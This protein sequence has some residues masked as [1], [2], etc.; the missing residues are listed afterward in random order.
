[1]DWHR[2]VFAWAGL[3]MASRI[4][5]ELAVATDLLD[6]V[7]GPISQRARWIITGASLAVWGNFLPK[8]LSPWR[9]EDEPFDW[10]RVHRFAGWLFTVAGVA[11]VA[12]W[13]V[14]PHPDQAKVL[15]RAILGTAA[16]LGV[17][18]KLMSLASP[19]VRYVAQSRRRPNLI[20][21]DGPIS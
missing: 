5:V 16:V 10:S 13:L 21:P 15:S 17:G 7:W 9:P 11:V 14:A 8:V 3:V 18:R 19:P 20:V 12:V 1:M 4:G 6:P 2:I